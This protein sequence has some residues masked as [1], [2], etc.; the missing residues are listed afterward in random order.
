MRYR[1]FS[2]LRVLPATLL[3]H[4]VI[5]VSCC[6]AGTLQLVSVID[7]TQMPYAT[8]GGDSL[9]PLLSADGRYVLFASTARNL[10]VN[11]NGIHTHL[12]PYRP[13]SS[14]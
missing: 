11:T 12:G 8:G 4:T 13:S 14:V 5:V 10:V 3:L 1:L 9:A 2:L 6:A 7:P